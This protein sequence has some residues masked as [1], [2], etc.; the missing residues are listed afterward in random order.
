MLAQLKEKDDMMLGAFKVFVTM[1]GLA[2]SVVGTAV[3]STDLDY[4]ISRGFA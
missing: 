4:R 3:G 2:R 1:P